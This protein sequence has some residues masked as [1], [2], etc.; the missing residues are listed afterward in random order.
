MSL[1]FSVRH[2]SEVYRVYNKC[3]K[4]GPPW[5]QAENKCSHIIKRCHHHY[6]KRAQPG[7][8]GA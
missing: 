7:F 1:L 6:I 4:A 5:L 2:T 3:L 8:K